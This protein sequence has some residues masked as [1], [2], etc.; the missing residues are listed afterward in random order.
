[1]WLIPSLFI[2]S[3]VFIMWPATYRL[4]PRKIIQSKNDSLRIQVISLRW[5][6]VFIYPEQNIAT[7][8]YV[9]IPVDTPVTFELTA[10][11]APMSS[12]W[13]PNLGGQLYSMTS[14]V[15]QLNLIA[16]S[17][18]EYPGSSAEI[19]GAGFAGM[20]FVT[21]ASSKTDFDAWVKGVK[22]SEKTL[23][24]EEYSALLR[25]SESHPV[26]LYSWYDG[27][28]YNKV[29]SKYSGSME[30]HGHTE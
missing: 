26:E 24:T 5:K 8:N 10:D 12:F 25:P 1:M 14:H 20:K 19:N 30:G 21:K 29:I 22:Q 2:F 6:W 18:G 9:Q 3:L 7:V 15:N 27:G 11:E 16:E 13:I 4:T 23:D 17:P 28:I